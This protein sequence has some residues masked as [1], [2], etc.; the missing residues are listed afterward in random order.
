MLALKIFVEESEL[1]EQQVDGGNR[2]VDIGQVEDGSEE[3]AAAV[4][5]EVEPRRAVCPVEEREVEHIDHLPHQEGGIGAAEFGHLRRGGCREDQ[6]V[7]GA[8]EDVADGS[9]QHQRQ[10]DNGTRGGLHADQAVD[11]PNQEAAQPHAEEAQGDL[12]PIHRSAFGDL[13]AEGGT[14]VFDE[15]QLE[16]VGDEDDGLVDGQ[17]GLD[18]D[19]QCLVGYDQQEQ[20]QRYFFPVHRSQFLWF[21]R[22]IFVVSV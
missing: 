14:V 1:E 4:D 10:A 22:A 9:G 17:V 18:P 11:E 7:E 2:N 12:S 13:H 3:V 8:V 6:S 16:P 5:Q 20:E 15:A 21:A 19:L